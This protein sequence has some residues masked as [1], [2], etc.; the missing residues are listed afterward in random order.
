MTTTTNLGLTTYS[1]ESGSLTSF[2]DYRLA[3]AG[4]TTSNLIKLDTWAGETSGSVNSLKTHAVYTA[5][6]TE[7][8]SN[9]YVSTVAGVSSYATNLVINLKLNTS[10]TGS[11]TINLN[12]LGDIVLKKVNSSGTIVN[13][14]TGDIILNQYYIFVYNGVNFVMVSGGTSSGSSG[15]TTYGGIT[16]IVVSGSEISHTT[17]G[18]VSGSYNAVDVNSFG[19]V[20]GGSNINYNSSIVGS[21]IM[22][23]TTGSVVNHNVSAVTPGNYLATNLTVDSTGHITA[24][25]S[26]VSASSVGAPSDSPFVMFG[27]ASN[28][29][30]YRI[31]TAGS[32]ISFTSASVSGG[33]IIINST[34][35]SGSSGLTGWFNVKDYGAVGNGSD[36]DTTAIQDAI[37]AAHTD[38]GIVYFPAGTYLSNTITLYPNVGMR[39][40]SMYASIIESSGAEALFSCQNAATFIEFS[41]EIADLTLDGASTGTIGMDLLGIYNLTV[42]R[43][44]VVGF[45]SIGLKLRAVLISWFYDCVIESSVKGIDADSAT[46]S[47]SGYV[48]ANLIHFINCRIHWH[49]SW[50]VYFKHGAMVELN[51]CDL[52]G[53]GTVGNAAT[54][55]VYYAP[56]TDGFGLRA[57]GCWCEANHGFA[58]FYIVTPD[59]AGVYSKD[60]C[61]I[62]DTVIQLGDTT[63]GIYVDGS[64]HDNK[65][66][67]R[68]V[69]FYTDYSGGDFYANGAGAL[70]H[71]YSGEGTTGGS[72]T[73]EFIPGNPN[74][75]INPMTSVGDMIYL[76]PYAG[77]GT[78][79]A[80]PA[81]G[82]SCTT[83]NHSGSYVAA[84]IIDGDDSTEWSAS[85]APPPYTQWIKIDLGSAKDVYGYRIHELGL[86][87]NNYASTV[88]ILGSLDD[89][90]Y[91]LIMNSTI[92]LTADYGDKTENFPEQEN[93]RYIKFVATAGG[94]YGWVVKTIEVYGIPTTNAPIALPIGDE[95]DI[96]A[97]DGGIP[98]WQAPPDP[99]VARS[100]S[101]TDGHLAVWNGNSADSIKDGGV[102]ITTLD[103]LS[104]VDIT[105]T[106]TGDVIYN[107]GSGWVD[108]PLGLGSK[109]YADGN[110]IRI[111]GISGANYIEIDVTTGNIRLIGNATSW[112]DV[113]VSGSQFR[114][115]VTAPALSAFGPSGNLRTYRFESAKHQEV[116]FEI[117]MPHRWKEGSKIY[118]H[119]HWTPISA[120]TGNVVWELEYAWA[121]INGAF[122]APSNMAS[123]PAAAGG[124]AWVHKLSQFKSGGNA[125]IE[126]TGQTLSSMLVCRMHR[127]AGSGSDTLADDVALLEFDLHYE[128]DGF[129]SDE[130]FVKDAQ[131]A[132]ILNN[133]SYFLLNSGDM[134]LLK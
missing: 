120:A 67:C 133:G 39:G 89:N 94:I 92:D 113:R 61:S 85:T 90:T 66:I 84:N 48:Q 7:V 121:S 75:M 12:S 26:G 93:Y 47:S 73:I 131:S 69:G 42:S 16:P 41:S 4:T 44:K 134:L 98:S 101:T 32:N 91:T 106:E 112:D 18:I 55:N 36:N 56:T 14:T 9:Y 115:G 103:S 119:V 28:V 30:N 29:T 24:A 19:H 43:V 127:N 63:Y 78:N 96:L 126:G 104:D 110:K 95:G 8:S 17:S 38:G 72:G 83:A 23:D 34:A 54:G 62:E 76:Y 13:L 71:I 51:A 45:T 35:T 1:S 86:T 117:Q 129:G 79:L 77:S 52:S 88:Q 102:V 130:E 33:N 40:V 70:I 111:G 74:F 114:S 97:V 6:G 109:I 87:S 107:S 68:S 3:T 108:Y 31:L 58:Q 128:V 123:D 132:M 125:Y 50:G 46:L 21:G 10:I 124:T 25:V 80:T 37:D 53:N 5:S 65:V 99:G 105:G 122:G 20:T 15:G 49:T 2:L 59:G 81:Q 22:S 11:A 27:S 118:P 64:V 60:Y 57:T 100:G 116:E 82:A